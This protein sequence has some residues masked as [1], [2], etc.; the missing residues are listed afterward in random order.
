MLSVDQVRNFP[1]F[2]DLSG[3]ELEALAACMF[4]GTFVKGTYIFRPGDPAANLYLVETGLVRVFFCNSQGDEFLL[5][6]VGP[7]SVI[8]LPLKNENRLRLLGAVAQFPTTLLSLSHDD[9]FRI[10]KSSNQLLF[11]MYT[12]VTPSLE[13]LLAHYQSLIINGLEGRT[14]ALF[15]LLGETEADEID[16]PVS[17]AD[18]ASWLG[19]SRGRLNLT[20]SKFQKQGLIRLD[21]TKLHILNRDR[22]S[23]LAEGAVLETLLRK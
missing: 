8:G 12:N 7:Q 16:I 9:L 22:L 6:L 1:L 17:Q 23:G 4:R 21:G 5:N 15:L 11:N 3:F 14:A 20:L 18:L 2:K 10:A 13:Y 19:V